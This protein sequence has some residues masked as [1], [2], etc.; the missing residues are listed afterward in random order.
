MIYY[1]SIMDKS[2]HNSKIEKIANLITADK[3]SLDEQ[4]QSKLKKYD[5]Y[6]RQTI[7]LV[8]MKH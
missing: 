8:M 1:L 7:I 4:D 3:I 2:D 5:V 6:K